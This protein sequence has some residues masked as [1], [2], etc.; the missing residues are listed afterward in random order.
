MKKTLVALAVAASFSL[1]M[2]VTPLFAQNAPPPPPPPMQQGMGNMQHGMHHHR[3]T[4]EAWLEHLTRMLNLTTEQQTQ[5]KPILVERDQKMQAIWKD[6]SLTRA[7]QREQMMAEGKDSRT[8]IEAVLNPDQKQKYDTMLHQRMERMRQMR[9]QHG[10]HHGMMSPEHQLEHLTQALNLTAEQQTQIKPILAER[11]QKMRAI[12]QE[13]REQMMAEG[14][15][16][17]AK[18]EAVLTPEQQQKFD[19]MM[20]QR[21]DRMHQWRQHHGAP[22]TLPPPPPPPPPAPPQ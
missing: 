10:M 12:W 21:M 2:N 13:Q 16:S 15:E 20:H 17:R 9:Q 1:G 7:Q 8:K 4:P 3:M 14:K 5:I 11:D 6:Q 22:G 19:A 18:L